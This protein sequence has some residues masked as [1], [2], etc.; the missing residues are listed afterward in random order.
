MKR[1]WDIADCSIDRRCKDTETIF[2]S[3]RLSDYAAVQ[4][5]LLRER[6]RRVPRRRELS[7]TVLRTVD[8]SG[9]ISDLGKRKEHS[10]QKQF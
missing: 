4:C 6:E 10:V 2:L 3:I 1:D 5:A 9:R 7:V 8:H